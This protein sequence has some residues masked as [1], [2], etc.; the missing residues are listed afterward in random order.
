MVVYFKMPLKYSFTY[1]SAKRVL[2]IIILSVCHD[3]VPI[4]AQVR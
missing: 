4:Q 2:A 3:Q 1:D